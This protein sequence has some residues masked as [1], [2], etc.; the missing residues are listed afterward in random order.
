MNSKLVA[1]VAIAFV[2]SVL[3]L[4]LGFEFIYKGSVT[5]ESAQDPSV[6]I[7]TNSGTQVM[8][9]QGKS[10]RLTP[11]TYIV[12]AQTSDAGVAKQVSVGPLSSTK[13]SLQSASKLQTSLVAHVPLYGTIPVGT[14][15]IG[16]DPADE[17]VKRV[18]RLGN[19]T[20][21]L[22]S[23]V[24]AG[25][26]GENEPELPNKVNAYEPYQQDQ[27]LVSSNGLLYVISKTAV[28][29]L[30]IEGIPIDH[31]STDTPQ[32]IIATQP[33]LGSFIVSY[34]QDI[35]WYE[36][37]DSKP[38]KIYT[39][40]KKF[41]SLTYGT[42]TIG[43]YAAN[44][45]TSKE[46]LSATLSGYQLDL[47]LVNTQ[48]HQEQTQAGPVSRAS[49]SPDSKLVTITPRDQPAYLY[50]TQSKKEVT[51]VDTPLITGPYWVGETNY[52]YSKG[53]A[54]WEYDTAKQESKLIGELPGTIT[55]F[56]QHT[57]NDYLV[58][59]FDGVDKAGIY[60]LGMATAATKASDALQNIL[61]HDNENA[62]ITYTAIGGAPTIVITTKAILNN[63]SQLPQWRQ[64]TLAYRKQA[65]DYLTSNK[66]DLG[67]VTITYVPA[68]PLR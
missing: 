16:F 15:V 4:W 19:T 43:L 21:I 13:I 25:Q 17:T 65:L 59:T 53:K 45:P 34:K 44:T 67:A 8:A 49:L 7:T 6:T 22:S 1:Q 24:L 37:L 61:P 28:K 12:T 20:S 31:T 57:P 39:A 58:T 2:I 36:N 54:V 14:S 64:D 52:L 23:D 47:L 5:I 55:S 63:A 3:L 68:D 62:T 41:D 42:N 66:V 50:D 56:Y 29:E 38:K 35:F 10:Y 51:N 9:G 11:G 33:Q 32:F 27:A 48:N 60:R 18:D 40:K 30:N 26:E 46:N